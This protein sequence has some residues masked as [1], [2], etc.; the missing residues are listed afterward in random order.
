MH[1]IFDI[2]LSEVDDQPKFSRCKA[3]IGQN[4]CFKNVMVFFDGLYLDDYQV[5]DD[6]IQH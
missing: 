6:Q 2:L 1:A 3:K 5:I 4:L